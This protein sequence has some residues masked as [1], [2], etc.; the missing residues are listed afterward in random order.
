MYDINKCDKIEM[1][2]GAFYLGPS[3]KKTSKG[4]L[5]LNPKQSLTLH[6][7]P[8]GIEKLT[9]VKGSC[10]MIIYDEGNEKIV[11]LEEGDEVEIKGGVWHIHAN[12]Y[13]EASLTYWD[14]DGDITKIIEDI[15]KGAEE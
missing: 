7:R 10:S 9:Q 8:Q 15:R 14:F 2:Q 5:E 11:K 12:P 1:P 4:Y 3:D 6:N 13:N